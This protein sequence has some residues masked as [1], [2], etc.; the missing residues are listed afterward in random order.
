MFNPFLIIIAALLIK[1]GVSFLDDNINEDSFI[2]TIGKDV[3][4]K[5]INIDMRV[6]AHLLVCGLSGNGKS[7]MVEYSLKNKD[8]ILFNVYSDNFQTIKSKK[9]NGN[10]KILKYLNRFY[11]N[12]LIQR[13]ENS[14]PLYLVFDDMLVLCFDKKIVEVIL[15][16]LSVARHHNVFLIGIS[17][18]GTKE[19]V[20]FKD[21]FNTRV[22]FRQVE[23][24]SYKSVLGYTP[25]NLKLNKREFYYYSADVG[26]G[27]TI[28]V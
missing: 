27:Y 3:K 13:D 2:L 1:V 22:C 9:I 11:Q 19:S 12:M 15:K 21:L 4:G 10:D 28:N 5:L 18:I 24:S 26:K 16:L 14:S 23:D 25:D 7:K 6:T 8:C 17:Q 20:K